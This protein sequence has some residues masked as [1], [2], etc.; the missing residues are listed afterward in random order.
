[1]RA[2]V[3]LSTILLLAAF[4]PLASASHT[5]GHRYLVYGRVLDADGM[6][7]QDQSV[8]LKVLS[9]GRSIASINTK[10]DCLGDFENWDGTPGSDP[11]GGGQVEQQT[12]HDP[13]YIAFHFHSNELSDQYKI[14]IMV[15]GETWTENFH[16]NTRQSSVM[17]QLTARA[18]PA[19]TC[20]GYDEFNTTFTFR[21]SALAPAEMKT[22]DVEPLKR[23]VRIFVDG[24]EAVNGT[25]DYNGAFF[26]KVNNRTAD[27]RVGSQVRIEAT[28]VGAR[29]YAV[30]ADA[31][32]FRRLDNAYVV[33]DSIDPSD[34]TFLWWL[35]GI[36]GV[37]GVVFAG[38]WGY[39]RLRSSLEES[40]LRQSTTRRRFR[41]GGE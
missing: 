3:L 31:L 39:S 32:K 29:S 2:P 37:V 10:T 14:Q 11:P 15:A 33:A 1:M 6:P 22:G 40:R 26:T 20:G 9:G 5:M 36:G 18:A 25:T 21:V 23:T 38:F 17:H 13:P 35:L 16:S 28:D 12:R 7:V 34:F 24:E 4:V 41:K 19:A 27:P 8:V 30:S